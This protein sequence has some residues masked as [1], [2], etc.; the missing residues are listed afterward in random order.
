MVF[1]EQK[2]NIMFQCKQS[3]KWRE[4]V[5]CCY[6]TIAV[7]HS[8]MTCHFMGYSKANSPGRH[9]VL[10]FWQMKNSGDHCER[11][12]IVTLS[13]VVVIHDKIFQMR[14]VLFWYIVN[15]VKDW[16]FYMGYSPPDYSYMKTLIEFLVAIAVND[17]VFSCLYYLH[18]FTLAFHTTLVYSLNMSFAHH[19]FCCF[20]FCNHFT[21]S[22]FI[23]KNSQLARFLI[24][25]ILIVE[26]FV[27]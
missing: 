18:Q 23:D 11:S 21:V 15:E 1:N 13:W 6:K 10:S 7:N 9:I 3:Q 27:K 19:I 24:W 26:N 8:V 17:S 2:V 5:D 14:P 25:N 16:L 22:C 12:L 4:N 20:I